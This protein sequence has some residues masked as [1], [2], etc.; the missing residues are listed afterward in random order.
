MTNS[1]SFLPQSDEI[2]ILDNGEITDK[3]SYSHLIE[4]NSKFRDFTHIF[5]Q[6]IDKK[7]NE[8]KQETMFEQKNFVDNSVT[9][10]KTEL[11]IKFVIFNLFLRI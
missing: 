2:I 8:N 5:M 9:V 3:G 10:A 1:L 11:I 4:H 6:L 7:T